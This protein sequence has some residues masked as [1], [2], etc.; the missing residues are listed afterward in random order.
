MP[1]VKKVPVAASKPAP[2]AK[3]VPGHNGGPP[4]EGGPVTAKPKAFKFPKALGECADLIYDLK[5]RRLAAQHVAEAIEKEEK[6]LK[7]HIIKNLP[8]SKAGGISGMR[9]NVQI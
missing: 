2:R 4:L 6:A 8:K 7:E 9:A 5:E 1:V 3:A